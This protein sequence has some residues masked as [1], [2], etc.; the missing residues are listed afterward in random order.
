MFLYGYSKFYIK[1]LHLKVYILT[2][3]FVEYLVTFYSN[4]SWEIPCLHIKKL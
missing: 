2:D 1:K 3:L 4:P